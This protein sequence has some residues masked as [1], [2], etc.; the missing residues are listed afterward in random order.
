MKG[1]GIMGVRRGGRG[2]EFCKP[3]NGLRRLDERP[4]PLLTNSGNNLIIWL[5]HIFINLFI[6]ELY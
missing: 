2:R 1:V 6:L 5:L 4:Q 3:L